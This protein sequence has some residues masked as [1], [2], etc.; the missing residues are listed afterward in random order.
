MLGTTEVNKVKN[1]AIDLMGKI[2]APVADNVDFY[3]KLGA[4]YLMSKFDNL[5][6]GGAV[7]VNKQNIDNFNVAYGAGIDYSITPNIIANLEW[8]RFNGY[9]RVWDSSGKVKYQPH[10]DAFMVGLRYKFDV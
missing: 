1:S 3:A 7:S 2:K 8:L 5:T 4:N 9:T 6:L 10:T